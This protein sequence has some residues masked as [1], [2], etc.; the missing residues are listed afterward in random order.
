MKKLS[1][2]LIVA[3]FLVFTPQLSESGFWEDVKGGFLQSLNCKAPAKLLLSPKS[4]ELPANTIIYKG[5]GVICGKL[6]S[7]PIRLKVK[8]I[9]EKS[10]WYFAESTATKEQFR[11][12]IQK[13][14]INF[15][16]S[17][18][19]DKSVVT[20]TIE[21][22]SLLAKKK[23]TTPTYP[24]VLV[25]DIQK[26]LNEKGYNAGPAD[27]IFGRGTRAAL[28]EFQRDIG[29]EVNGR[30]DIDTIAALKKS[31]DNTRLSSKI[32]NLDVTESA[33]IDIVNKTKK[34]L[35]QKKVSQKSIIS[36]GQHSSSNTNPVIIKMNECSKASSVSVYVNNNILLWKDD[37]ARDLLLKGAQYRQN[38][39]PNDGSMAM[40]DVYVAY[41]SDN[42]Y[43]LLT[44]L[45]NKTQVSATFPIDATYK[46]DK[47]V[48]Y[49]N[50]AAEKRVKEKRLAVEKRK[51]DEKIAKDRKKKM[52][53]AK[54]A[55]TKI[56]D[57][58]VKNISC[59]YLSN[60]THTYVKNNIDY[61]N[62][63]SIENILLQSATHSKNT[64]NTRA[65]NVKVSLI[66]EWSMNYEKPVIYVD[67]I[68]SL[69]NNKI[70]NQ[71][72][73][74]KRVIEKINNLNKRRIPLLEFYNNTNAVT[75][76]EANK[77]VANPYIH[78][79][80]IVVMKAT[81]FSMIDKSS[82]LF[83]A[84]KTMIGLKGPFVVIDVPT[85]RFQEEKSVLLATKILGNK[86]KKIASGEEVLLTHASY[87][88]AYD[89]NFT[90]EDLSWLKSKKYNDMLVG[91]WS[92]NCSW[93]DYAS[94]F[95]PD[96]SVF[97]TDSNGT[98]KGYW[99]INDNIY[100]YYS[101]N[102]SITKWKLTFITPDEYKTY[103]L[104]KNDV[105]C[106]GQRK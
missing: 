31:Q 37:V 51:R 73:Y 91:K 55:P 21:K 106:T 60:Y 62:Y 65:S 74:A 95:L 47:Y 54:T 43:P 105:L 45:D 1:T 8:V 72:N 39:C 96:G 36:Q 14:N 69:K 50:V 5:P 46:L 81:F 10:D 78:E 59:H 52:E 44:R 100:N 66:P 77:I 98:Q 22:K 86:R 48:N 58:I 71:N 13:I 83:G 79:D 99:E 34:P 33:N 3:C 42:K 38:N 85:S 27:G 16:S 63:N 80:D 49:N 26:R 93:G 68:V 53:E 18:D 89:D 57:L 94:E 82:A 29:H 23:S 19:V 92:T 15:N 32:D 35:L 20:N 17:Q 12:W 75:V 97:F 41:K 84:E 40:L 4:G 7:F 6:G 56:G 9:G 24:K 70:F 11:G 90:N 30:L 64:C 25:L 61:L 102:G 67:A 101:L 87:V 104:K 88:D 28:K 103:M 2:Y 76:A